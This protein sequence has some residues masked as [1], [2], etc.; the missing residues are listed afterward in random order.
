MIPIRD[1]VGAVPYPAA[2]S[3]TIHH[4]IDILI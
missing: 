4:I 1:V 3:F 2:Q